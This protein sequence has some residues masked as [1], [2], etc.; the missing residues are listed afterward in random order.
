MTHLSNTG[1]EELGEKIVTA[2]GKMKTPM[3]KT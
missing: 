1:L 3:H 2:A